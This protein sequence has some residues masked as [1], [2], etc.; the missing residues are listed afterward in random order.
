MVL[1]HSLI[2]STGLKLALLAASGVL[3][4][5][6]ASLFKQPAARSFSLAQNVGFPRKR[7]LA[8]N[9]ASPARR[10]PRLSSPA[11]ATFYG[12]YAGY[13]QDLGRS[14]VGKSPFNPGFRVARVD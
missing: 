1:S 6:A 7:L 9:P 3:Q 8:F 2:A 12:G 13:F 5:R 14:P 11:H 4:P 10:P